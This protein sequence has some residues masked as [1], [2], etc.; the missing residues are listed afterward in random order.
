MV[1]SNYELTLT[2]Q[3]LAKLGLPASLLLHDSCPGL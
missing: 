1:N 2:F 3:Q